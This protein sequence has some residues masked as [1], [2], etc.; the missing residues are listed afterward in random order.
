MISPCKYGEKIKTEVFIIQTP[1]EVGLDLFS[2]LELS[3]VTHGPRMITLSFLNMAAMK[4]DI[5]RK[6]GDEAP[7]DNPSLRSKISIIQLRKMFT[8]L[9]WLYL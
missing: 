6:M 9:C 2:P 3:Y 7:G 8:L 4:Q 5:P 1:S